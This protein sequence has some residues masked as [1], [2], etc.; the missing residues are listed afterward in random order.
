MRL[1]RLDQAHGAGDAGGVPGA[2][3]AGRKRLRAELAVRSRP[4]DPTIPQSMGSFPIAWR[5]PPQ[6]VPLFERRCELRL[7]SSNPFGYEALTGGAGRG[8]RLLDQFANVLTN[9]RDA[10]VK[11]CET[12]GGHERESFWRAGLVFD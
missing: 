3:P 11:V 8:G 12:G 2:R 10:G 9:R 6:S 4:R 1:P 5:W 7:I